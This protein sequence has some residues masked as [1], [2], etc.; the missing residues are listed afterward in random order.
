MVVDRDDLAVD[1]ERPGHVQVATQCTTDAF[2]HDGLAV[3]RRPVK[4]HGLAGVHG[5]AELIE[6]LRVDDQMGEPV[7]NP[8]LVEESAPRLHLVHR[9]DVLLERHWRR[10]HVRVGLQVVRRALAS[11][12]GEGVAVAGRAR[13]LCASDLDELL[14]AQMLDEGL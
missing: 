7:R 9:R 4:E 5:R 8:V 11:Q 13:A 10:P 6:H 14:N 3:P 1:I 12:V 2:G